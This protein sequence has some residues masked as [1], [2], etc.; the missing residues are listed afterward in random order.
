VYNDGDGSTAYDVEYPLQLGSFDPDFHDASWTV[1]P[2]PFAMMWDRYPMIN[3]RGYPDTVT[4]GTI[5]QPLDPVSGED[6]NGPGV[7]S[8]IEDSLIVA[9]VGDR[10]L[11]RLSNLN[12]TVTHTL[13]SPSIPMKVI[14]I[15]AKELRA[16][17]G[18]TP[19]H[20]TTNSVTM[21]GG[22]SFDVI[23]DTAGVS[24]GTY[25]LYAANLQY[26]SNLDEDFGGMMTEIRIQ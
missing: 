23:L 26:L 10:I 1:Q 7:D 12:I 8:Q 19:L 15:D 13:I 17:D 20:Y 14:G 16:T 2:L 6:L 24:A 18:L 11:L 5:D 22:M 25:Y 3:G 21:G 9:S 4:I